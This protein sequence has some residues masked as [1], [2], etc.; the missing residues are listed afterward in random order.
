ML[1][2]FPAPPWPLAL[3]RGIGYLFG[4]IGP[5]KTVGIYVEDQT[6]AVEFYV[7]KLG[8]VLRRNLPMGPEASWIEVSPVGAQSSLVLY[9]RSMMAEWPQL[10]PSVVFHSADVEAECE[11]LESLGVTITMPATPLPWGTFAK[12]TDPDGNEFGLTSQEIAT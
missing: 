7:R 12:F 2:L 6:R 1:E 9:P 5:V 11:R 10:K 4:M 3:P 8:F